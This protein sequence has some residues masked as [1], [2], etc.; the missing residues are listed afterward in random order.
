[1]AE[2]VFPLAENRG[3]WAQTLHTSITQRPKTGRPVLFIWE[4]NTGKFHTCEN[5]YLKK[6]VD[7][8]SAFITRQ[9]SSFEM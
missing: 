1:M 7:F 3:L 2:N 8:L 4:E 6:V 5:G 9:E